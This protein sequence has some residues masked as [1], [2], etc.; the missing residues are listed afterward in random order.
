MSTKKLI[1]LNKVIKDIEADPY[2][3]ANSISITKL[4]NI[5]INL[6]NYYYNTATP[7]ISDSIYDLLREILEQRDPTNKFLDE[8]GS[9]VSKDKV[10]LPY[11]MASLNKIKPTSNNLDDWTKKFPGPYIKSDKLDG[12]SGELFKENDN[13]KLYT[14][15]DSTSGQDISHLIP[16]LLDTKLLTKIPNNTAIRG[17]II[18]SK[19]N[20]EKI[21]D[22]YSNARNTVSGLVNSK[23]FSK[24]V[25]QLTDFISYSIL[26]PP[27]N[28]KAQMLKLE[29]WKIP[30][31]NYQISDTLSYDM[32]SNDFKDRRQNSP[33]EVDGI[34]VTDSS[35]V[36][37]HSDKNPDFSFAFKMVLTDQVAEVIVTEVEWNVTKHQYIK[38]TIK[39]EPVHLV[40]VIIKSVT[41]FNG[42]YVV[43]NKLGPGAILKIVRSG[44]VIPHIL[45]VIKPAKSGKPQLPKL[46]YT[47]TESGVD[48]IV[49]KG[50]A[51]D[52]IIIKQ[53]SHFFKTMGVKYISEGII[54]KLVNNGY[55]TVPS[56]LNTDIQ[57]L[58]EIDGIGNTVLTKIFENTR[59]AF[60]TTNLETVMAASNIFGVGFGV[61]KLKV[62]V[63]NIPDIMDK[64]SSKKE[65]I[66]EITALKSFDT[67]TA[68]Q[69]SLHIEEFK[70]FFKTLET[71]KLINVK[72]L[73][74][75]KEIII[76]KVNNNKELFKDMKVV[77]T[78]IRDKEAE[79]FIEDNGG[80][81]ST[82]VSKNTNLLVYKDDDN[83]SAK[84]TKAIELD[85]KTVSYSDFKEKYLV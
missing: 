61:R 49:K 79:K 34:V 44:D 72:Q 43:D 21:K 3:Y 57:T 31:V 82:S 46:D 15:G 11:P 58:S 73:L 50:L 81:I 40:G 25:A 65:L 83:L 78:G 71:I 24:E 9:P 6:S 60:E 32:L 69:F 2:A 27:L 10:S 51:S 30:T 62:I 54:T 37:S 74:G 76:K 77:F 42:K 36:Y 63:N 75:K 66:E 80:S 5:L 28:A 8:I 14:R 68:T 18:I 56:I 7:L 53:L 12:V 4:V 38:P 85:I 22:Q 64:K 48:M 16:Y 55:K 47:W 84:Y 17:E 33:Y 29:S 20:F 26:N 13:F 35:K 52:E 23:H 41:A 70:K 59:V 67:K 45:E 19:S 39:I 1:T